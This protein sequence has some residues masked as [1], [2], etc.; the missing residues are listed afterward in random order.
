MR[1]G[2]EYEFDVYGEMDQDN[3]LRIT[4]SRCPKLTGARFTKPGEKF[5]NVLKQ[6]LA[7]APT[8]AG[9]SD[10]QKTAS[11]SAS[12]N[13][14]VVNGAGGLK[15]AAVLTEE[16]AA[17]WKRMCSPRG[18]AKEFEQLKA[19]VEQL[20]GSTGIAEYSRILREH[21]AH[22]PKRFKTPQSARLCAKDVYVLLEKLRVNARENTSPLE[23]E[24]A[25]PPGGAD[26]PVVN[27]RVS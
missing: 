4:K 21:G 22:H 25:L 5:A 17:I 6:W 12:V 14:N 24:S 2:I 23:S 26:E 27:G 3:T 1:D 9:K 10:P 13:S 8:P 20:A 16:L 15:G 11:S 19:A 18:I 7:G